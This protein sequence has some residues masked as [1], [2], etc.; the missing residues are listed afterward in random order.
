MK[1]IAVISSVLLASLLSSTALAGPR[2]IIR[3]ARFAEGGKNS[4]RADGVV[5]IEGGVITASGHGFSISKRDRSADDVIDAKGGLVLPGFHDSHIHML[6]GG[7]SLVRAQ[8]AGASTLKA[9]Q[10]VVAAYAKAHPERPWIMGRGWSYGIVPTGTMPTAKM[11]DDVV[12]D[13]PVFIRA[14]DGHTGWANTKALQLAGITKAT[15]DPDDG[16]IVRDN[17]GNPTGALKEGAQDL[18]D[19]ALPQP[20]R[21]EKKA[22]LLAAAQ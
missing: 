18:M 2:T 6:G 22:A 3:N 5:V 8:L 12:S 7:L 20:T 19:K 14:Y 21:A 4:A 16:E 15:K 13:R 17:N 9:L 11:L 1:K 10:D